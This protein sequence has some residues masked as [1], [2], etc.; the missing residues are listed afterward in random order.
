VEKHTY[1][2]RLHTL[3]SWRNF[4]EGE[5]KEMGLFEYPQINFHHTKTILGRNLPLAD[6]YGQYINGKLN[7]LGAG[8]KKVRIWILIF[9]EKDRGLADEQE[10]YWK[11]GNKNEFVIMMNADKDNVLTW[12]HIMSPTEKDVLKINVRDKLTLKNFVI[13]DD[14]ML[15]FMK[16]LEIE[17]KNDY[18]KPDYRQYAYIEVVPSLTA[19]IIS[20]II[21][22]VV[23]V[24][25]GIFVIKNSWH[26][27]YN[28]ELTLQGAAMNVRN[29]SRSLLYEVVKSLGVLKLM[30]KISGK[31][32][33]K[34]APLT[35]GSRLG[36]RGTTYDLT[37]NGFRPMGGPSL[38]KHPKKRKRRLI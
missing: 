32:I 2:N 6:T 29:A 28:E 31:K 3:S 9:N 38:L 20:Y 11:G 13:N 7:T 4:K 21:M 19:V 30:D 8:Y 22:F 26:D 25:A 12:A 18:V 1:E 24:G 16:W 27:K 36:G 34:V 5:A 17:I 23:N 14:N 37:Q 33:Q 10:I 15:D 35:E